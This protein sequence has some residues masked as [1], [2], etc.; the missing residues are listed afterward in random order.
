MD[1]ANDATSQQG[2]ITRQIPFAVDNARSQEF[3]TMYVQEQITVS[4]QIQNQWQENFV[5]RDAGQKHVSYKE[6]LILNIK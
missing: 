3:H 4:F 2:Y 6:I 1:E 5:T